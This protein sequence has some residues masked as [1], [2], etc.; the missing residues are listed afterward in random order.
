[1]FS[2]ALYIHQDEIENK[3]NVHNMLGD[4]TEM[5]LASKIGA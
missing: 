4:E 3:R 1:M 2:R 5:D